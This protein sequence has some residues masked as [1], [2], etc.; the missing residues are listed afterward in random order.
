PTVRAENP[1]QASGLS[2][3]KTVNLTV[4]A[5]MLVIAT[6]I[7]FVGTWSTHAGYQQTEQA[8]P[9]PRRDGHLIM[10]SIDGMPP[11]YYTNPA[12]IG[13]KVPTLTSMKLNGAYADGVEGVYPAVTYPAHTTLVTGVLPATHGIV[14][15]RIFEPPTEPQTRSWYWFASGLKVETLWMAAKKAGLSVGT[16]GWPVTAGA[17]VDYN[18]PE[19]WDPPE[20]PLTPK[21]ALQY[22]TPGLVD[23]VVSSMGTSRGDQFPTSVAEYIIKNYKPNLLLLHLIELD[24]THHHA[25]PRSQKAI[26]VMEREDGYISRIIQ[27]TRDAGI[28]DS[29]TVFVVSDHGFASVSKKFEPNVVLARAGLIN[30]DSS[31]KAISWKAAAW[32]ADG[33]CAIVLHDPDDRATAKQVTEIFS[34]IA[35]RDNSPIGQVLERRQLDRLGAIPQA[36]IM[37]EAST[38]FYFGGDL[39]GPETRD[40][41]KEYLGTHCYL[42]SK[43]EMCS[44]LVI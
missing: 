4:K 19:V 27:A 25:G 12:A 11:D 33:S 22:W 29:T 24:D 26:E 18:F 41:G 3:P 44:S 39:T 28:F 8:G 31:G 40:S 34:K 38:G 1:H 36:S 42:P 21:R 10:I 17:D 37:L 30:L 2:S 20:Q 14:Q 6:L 43:L 35:S 13:L 15:N 32:D 5:I 7:L 23:K 9:I 16:V